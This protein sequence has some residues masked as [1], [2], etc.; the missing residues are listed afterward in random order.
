LD[1]L[2]RALDNLYPDSESILAEPIF[3]K[4]RKTTRFKTLLA[5]HFPETIH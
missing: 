2:E 5:K 4:I 1:W 3:V